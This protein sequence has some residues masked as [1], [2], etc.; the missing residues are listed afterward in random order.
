MQSVQTS[1]LL[2]AL[3]FF[4]P[5][6]FREI[7]WQCL[8]NSFLHHP[9]P[10]PL[11]S[12]LSLSIPKCEVSLSL[13]MDARPSVHDFAMSLLLFRWDRPDKQRVKSRQS[14]TPSILP[15]FITKVVHYTQET[16]TQWKH[17]FATCATCRKRASHMT[18]N[19]F[20]ENSRALLFP[21]RQF[22]VFVSVSFLNPI[23]SCFILKSG[24]K[25]GLCSIMFL[26]C[27]YSFIGFG[28]RAYYI[29]TVTLLIDLV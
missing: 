25:G 21:T 14:L 27:I 4:F 26:T 22:F 23:V 13:F 29:N 8:T 17:E 15:S 5:H 11:P 28:R 6:I 2:S 9:P 3:L 18:S 12:A 16:L 24:F 19:I 1:L 10:P 20:A 7:K